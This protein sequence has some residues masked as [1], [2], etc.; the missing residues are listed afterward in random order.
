MTVDK[1][2][3]LENENPGRAVQY[4]QDQELA[5]DN[6]FVT[7]D[8]NANVDA[9]EKAVQIVGNSPQAISAYQ[10]FK[11]QNFS[12]MDDKVPYV[13]NN[14]NFSD[15]QKGMMI[16]GYTDPSQ[17]KGTG[18]TGAYDTAGWEG[19]YYWYLMKYLA[20]NEFGDGNGSVKKSEKNALL[21]SDNP[22]VT[23]LLDEMY[24]YLAGLPNK[25]W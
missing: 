2:R 9:Y 13:M 25:A 19:V 1:Y 23:A 16:T 3:K 22:Y 21:N 15:D 7:K 18:V 17:L 8:G 20:D 24:Y 11:N 12:Y 10:E 6:G 4:K 5:L 14:S